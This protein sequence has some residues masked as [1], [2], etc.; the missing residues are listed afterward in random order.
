MSTAIEINH[1]TSIPSLGDEAIRIVDTYRATLQ[2]HFRVDQLI[3]EFPDEAYYLN[4]D[5]VYLAHAED[6]EA[7]TFKWRGALIGAAVLKCLGMESI[8]VPSAG[9]HL[10]GAVL[11][12]KILDM[13]IHGV[14]PITA[15]ASKRDG[16][17]ALWSNGKFKLHEIGTNFDDSLTWAL[18]HPELGALLHPYDNTHVIAGQGTLVD[19]ILAA[20]SDTQHIVMPVGGGGL[21]SGVL[22][23]LHEHDREDIL[24]H[25]IEAP[26]S[27]SLSRSFQA[28]ERMYANAPNKRYGGSAVRKIGEHT[29]R[30]C[31]TYGNLRVHSHVTEQLVDKV[32][33]NY[34]WSRATLLRKE[35]PHLEPTSMVAIAGLEAIVQEF[36]NDQIVVIGTGRNDSLHPVATDRRRTLGKNEPL[37]TRFK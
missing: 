5:N 37:I 18:E 4:T 34:E 13:N 30:V 8:V 6:N 23:R 25:A 15:P 14:V 31:T 11:A 24:V 32:I 19:D 35:T 28:N 1:Y 16:A 7:G 26:G 17:K 21:V 27:N 33:G 12:A 2:D 22:Q 29:M 3:D 9:N 36:P 10:R 20:K